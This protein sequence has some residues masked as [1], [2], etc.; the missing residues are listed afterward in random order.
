MQ[1]L[2]VLVIFFK[3]IKD[4]LNEEELM[5]FD[6][7]DGKGENNLDDADTDDYDCVVRWEIF[8][9]STNIWI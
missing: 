5:K 3:M 7:K 1:I 8:G 4:E 2:I 6:F 9:Y